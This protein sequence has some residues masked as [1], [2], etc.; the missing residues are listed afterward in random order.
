VGVS[1]NLTITGNLVYLD[2]QN[3]SVADAILELAANNS[4]DLIDI[5]ITGV[6]STNTYVG[7]ARDH[8][9]GIWKL[10]ESNTAPTTTANFT[11][12]GSLKVDELTATGNITGANIDTAGNVS[13]N[14]SVSGSSLQTDGAV[15]INN[16]KIQTLSVTT[17]TTNA[18][19]LGKVAAT[20]GTALHVLVKG[21]DSTG[22]KYSTASAMVLT[23]AA[24]NVDYSVYGA[25][26]MGGGAGTFTIV[27]AD[28]G[29]N[30][31][32]TVTSSSSNSTS[33]N[34]LVQLV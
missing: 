7:F 10:F 25:I 23:D 17:T 1:G 31:Q 6:V 16:S 26:D 32:I 13:A 27:T 9:D 30:V 28:A 34:A 14:G 3:A 21:S 20:A 22:G 33:W 2:V 12:L 24:G 4:S 8:T 11:T 5:G 18:T 29:A 19:A 15:E